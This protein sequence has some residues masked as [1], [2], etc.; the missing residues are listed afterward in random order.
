[1]KGGS[2]EGQAPKRSNCKKEGDT[3]TV[4]LM[5]DIEAWMAMEIEGYNSS[6]NEESTGSANNDVE[7]W[8]HKELTQEVSMR[9]NYARE[10]D[11]FGNAILFDSLESWAAIKVIKDDANETEE[12]AYKAENEVR[13]TIPKIKLYDSGAS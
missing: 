3:A 11:S 13:T 4:A 5:V 2:K 9:N 1:V 12:S 6:I 8:T 7:L 10:D